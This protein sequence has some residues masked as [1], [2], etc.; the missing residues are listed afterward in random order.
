MPPISRE[1]MFQSSDNNE[2]CAIDFVEALRL[3]GVPATRKNNLD[4][5]HSVIYAV[6]DL[7]PYI[8]LMIEVERKYSKPGARFAGDGPAVVTKGDGSEG[9]SEE[10]SEE[11]QTAAT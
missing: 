11:N 9:T 6:E 5:T 1:T 10:S 4:G 3:Q 8:S 2:A 7:R